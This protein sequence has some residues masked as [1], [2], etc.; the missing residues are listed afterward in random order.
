M[1]KVEEKV[2]R[3]LKKI[4]QKK[5]EKKVGKNVEK[6]VEKKSGKKMERVKNLRGYSRLKVLF[7][8]TKWAPYL[9][10]YFDGALRISIPFHT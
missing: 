3:K 9:F 7:N 8:G 5:I 2:G 4:V 10:T 1:K 6:K